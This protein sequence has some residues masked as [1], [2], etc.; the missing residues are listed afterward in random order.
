MRLD[1]LGWLVA[2]S[3][4]GGCAGNHVD[5]APAH[6]PAAPEAKAASPAAKAPAGPSPRAGDPS[7][8]NVPPAAPSAEVAASTA[9]EDAAPPATSV[10]PAA[11]RVA[12]TCADQSIAAFKAKDM[13]RIA[14]LAH[15][16]R[17]VRFT[18]F[19][20]VEVGRD[21]VLTRAD[22]E[23]AMTD[24][25]VRNWGMMGESDDS[26]EM[27]FA[28]YHA[29]FIYDADFARLGR[30]SGKG[31]HPQ[32]R[33]TDN[34]EVLNDV[35]RKTYPQGRVFEFHQPSRNDSVADW[36]VLRLVCQEQAGRFYLAGVIHSELTP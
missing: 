22:L 21:V 13:R 7:A 23:K 17:G 5:T 35:I 2:V 10:D 30:A 24:P 25:K 6:Q 26:I 9:P 33:S 12:E 18:P 36:R 4:A 19:S 15:P 16:T 8:V 3:L 28:Q 34:L 20:F 29:R 11:P 31:P 1:V 32:Q 27:T 14:R